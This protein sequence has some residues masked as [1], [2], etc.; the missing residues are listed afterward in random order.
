MAAA[1]ESPTAVSSDPSKLTKVQKLAV[2]MVMLGPESAANILKQLEESELDAVTGEMAKITMV[3]TE[4][5][6]EV[7]R[8]FSDVA[9]MASTSIR[10]GVEYTQD[11]LEKS[12]GSLKA[13]NVIARIGSP[14]APIAAMQDII[15]LDPRQIFSLIKQEQPQ[16]IAL[17][18]SYLPSDKASHFLLMLRAEARDQV[19]ERLA[20]LAPT[21]V[22]AVE[23]IVRIINQKRGV[24][25]TR[26]LNQTGG[27]KS[28]A[29][30]LKALDKTLSRALLVSIEERN[31]DLGQA[32]RQKMFTFEDLS[33]LDTESLQKLLR[34]VDMRDL[35]ISLKPA[36]ETLKTK[37][38]GCISKRAAEA[39]KEE[40][41]FL[42]PIKQRDTEAA[43]LRI[44]E[45][46]RRLE[47]EGDI[48]L[49]DLKP[50][51]QDEVLV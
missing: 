39:V 20:T 2:L 7:L 34:E 1:I 33:R 19:L 44:V 28:A 36:S 43:Q 14:R 15:D 37:L 6:A 27:V 3:G 26:A 31:P 4:L 10:G 13:S 18:V 5:Q 49:N 38:L 25:P 12:L 50:E 41:Q 35:A 40:I 9:V 23:A 8:E 45:A 17:I 51:P 48:D 24:N 16:T 21:P 22:E 47:S 11:V 46:V 32:I 29:D 30:L 42:G